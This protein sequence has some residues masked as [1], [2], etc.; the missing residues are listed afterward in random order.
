MIPERQGFRIL[1]R[2]DPGMCAGIDNKRARSSN[3]VRMSGAIRGSICRFGHGGGT[4]EERES[5]DR[6]IT[7][8]NATQT[9]TDHDAPSACQ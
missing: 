6:Q 9:I 5:E 3:R 4:G 8:P 2:A 1:H 7:G